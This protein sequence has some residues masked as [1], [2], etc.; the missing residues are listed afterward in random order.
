MAAHFEIDDE[1]IAARTARR[2]AWLDEDYEHLGR[3]L[4]APRRRHRGA[5]SRAGAA[6]TVAVPSW[7]VGTGGTRFARF[8]GPGEPRN[9][10]EKL[11]DC[12]TIF[13]LVRST[14]ARLAAHPLGQA[15][16]ARPSCARSRAQR[17]LHFDAMNSN[18]FQDQPGQ[19][20]SYKFGSLIASRRGGPPAGD[21]AQP[22]MH[23]DRRDARLD[24]AHGLDRRRRQLSRADALPPR[25]RALPRQHARDLRRAARRL[26]AVHRAQALRAGV[27]LDGDQRLGHELLLRARAR[28]EGAAASSTSATTRRTSTSR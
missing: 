15:P 25:A 16:R 3:Q 20:L 9:I 1:L 18:T 14:P 2:K 13:R 27:L 26:A 7:G 4:R 22:R 6:F 28:A 12:A 24:G 10:F 11:D 21:R 23:R 19:A 5:S 8:P 17:G